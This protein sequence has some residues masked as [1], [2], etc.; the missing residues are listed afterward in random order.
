MVTMNIEDW[1]RSGRFLRCQGRRIFYQDAGAGDALLCIHGFPTAS[2]DWHRLWPG[3]IRRFRVIAPDLL[4]FGF[5]D[6][7]TGHAYSLFA[8]ATLVEELL[9]ARELRAVHILAHDYGVTVAQELLARQL[10]GKYRQGAG[11]EIR[12]VTLLN[13]GLF[14]E[15]TRPLFI[16]KV[17]KHRL[18]GPVLARLL[19]ERTFRRSFS[20]VFAPGHRPTRS[21]LRAFWSL[22]AHNNGQR[23]AHRVSRY[24]DERREYRARWTRAL[25]STGVPLR[26]IIGP[27]DPVSGRAIA[28][29]FRELVADA[30]IVMLDGIGHYPQVEA[31]ERVLE[32]LFAFVDSGD[33]RLDLN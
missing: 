14:P 24:Q 8:Q 28:A 27:E 10:E 17:L 9:Q 31:P 33:S 32:A 11:V 6:K 18:A 1:Q 19:S 21:E 3:L 30:D 29:R 2:W 5:S 4:G 12:S 22:I 13:G 16:Q 26:L 7:P 23:V 15:A 25:Q 20:R